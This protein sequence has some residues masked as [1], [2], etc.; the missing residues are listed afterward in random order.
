MA[1]KIKNILVPIDG[2]KNSLR[3]L[4]E[5][6]AL[7]RNCQARI[8]GIHVLSIPRFGELKDC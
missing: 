8:T 5:A 2:S 6:I 7:A 3:G 4:D 1:I